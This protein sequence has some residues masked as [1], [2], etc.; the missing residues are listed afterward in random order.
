M[1]FNEGYRTFVLFHLKQLHVLD[2]VLVQAEEIDK[3]NEMYLGD[4]N[5]FI[6]KLNQLKRDS[7]EQ[8]KGIMYK[9]KMLEEKA[10]D[11]KKQ[12]ME[13][14]AGLETSVEESRAKV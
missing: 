4:M 8:V 3:I 6:T 14:F 12:L 9:R 13:S 11:T 7:K 1:V 10:V 5:G 2:A